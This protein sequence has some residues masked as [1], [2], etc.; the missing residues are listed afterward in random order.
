MAKLTDYDVII[1]DCYGTLCDWESGIYDALQPLLARY[2]S[3]A[4]WTRK[5][6]LLAFTEVEKNLQAKHPSVLY[7]DLLSNAHAVLAD[8]LQ[9]NHPD[10]VNS[11]VDPDE[12]AKFGASIKDWAIFPD[13]CAAL[14]V[15]QDHYKLVILSNVD[16]ASFAHTH[17]KLSGASEA[18]IATYTRPAD[19]SQWLPQT[20]PGSASPFSLILTAQDTGAYK[21]DPK[22]MLTALDIIAREFGVEKDK[23]LVVAQSLYH[24]IDPS[25]ALGVSGVW[26]N[27]AGA[28]MGLESINEGPKWTWQFL[29]LGEMAKAVEEEAK[30]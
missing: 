12:H 17:A 8:T 14:R 4:T 24:D 13:T 9:A 10:T 21:P 27:R 28:A 29:T 1:Y 20:T 5:E 23:V 25:N 11:D 22:G 3:S 26:I 2:P 18:E 6:A 16:H 7:R 19:G 15:L 30:S